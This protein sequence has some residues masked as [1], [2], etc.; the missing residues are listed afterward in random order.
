MK[1]RMGNDLA[2]IL[3]AFSKQKDFQ[4]QKGWT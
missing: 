3:L 1:G 2:A 4:I